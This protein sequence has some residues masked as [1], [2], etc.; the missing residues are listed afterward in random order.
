VNAREIHAV[1]TNS[2]QGLCVM[3]GAPPLPMIFAVSSSTGLTAWD[4][5]Y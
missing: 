4:S 2:G 5:V 3:V 1:P